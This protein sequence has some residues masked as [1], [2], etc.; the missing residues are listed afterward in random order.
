MDMLRSS[1]QK[2]AGAKVLFQE[3]VAKVLPLGL[4]RA[5]F[6]DILKSISVKKRCAQV[7]LE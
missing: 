1:E 5:A 6:R 2:A 7:D 3:L 4:G